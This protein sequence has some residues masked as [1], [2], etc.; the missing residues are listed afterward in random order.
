MKAIILAAGRGKRLKN[1]TDDKPKCLNSVGGKA[2]LDWQVSALRRGG[3]DTI[4]LVTGYKMEMFDRFGLKTFHNARW[5]SSNMVRSL[6]CA[7]Q[8][9]GEPLIVS[10]SDILYK[11]EIVRRL[12]SQDRDAVITYDEEWKKLWEERFQNPLDDAESFRI[13][14]DGKIRDIGRKPC[15]LEEI[16]GQYMGLMRFTP[17]ALRWI[18]EYTDRQ[19][20]AVLDKMDMTTL[21]RSLITERLSIY[22]MPVKGGW[23]EIDTINDLELANRLYDKGKSPWLFG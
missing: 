6:L 8:E 18:T 9:F 7:R 16:E 13:G 21:L 14:S 3:V 23:C 12:L 22:G 1:F 15:S 5:E 11:D 20:S 17:T 19:D 4:M 10:Y 2:M